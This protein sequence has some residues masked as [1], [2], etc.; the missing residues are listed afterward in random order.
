M[1]E[2]MSYFLDIRWSLRHWTV[3]QAGQTSNLPVGCT[4]ARL[5]LVGGFADRWNN[6]QL[7][8]ASRRVI[9]ELRFEGLCDDPATLPGPGAAGLEMRTGSRIQDQQH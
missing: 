6:R 8:L 3:G 9:D 5:K 4:L 1:R 7:F 2:G